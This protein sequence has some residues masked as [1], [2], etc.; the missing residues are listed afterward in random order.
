MVLQLSKKRSE[1]FLAF[2]QLGPSRISANVVTGEEECKIFFP[3]DYDIVEEEIIETT[4]KPSKKKSKKKPAK[5][6]EEGTDEQA[7]AAEDGQPEVIVEAVGEVE[8]NQLKAEVKNDGINEQISV[9][10]ADETEG[11]DKATSPMPEE[12]T[13]E[14]ADTGNAS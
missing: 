12:A 10:G 6:E 14:N 7:A 1:A 13:S 8:D 4:K 9:E 2:A 11:E 5:E 3:E